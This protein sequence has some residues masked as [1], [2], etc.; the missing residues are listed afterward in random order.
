[1]VF[2]SKVHRRIPFFALALAFLVQCG[3]GGGGSGPAPP[4]GPD[5]PAPPAPPAS[6]T[7]FESGDY[8]IYLPPEI[9]TFRGVYWVLSGVD[10]REI[11]DANS[12]GRFFGLRDFQAFRGRVL[13][14]AQEHGLAVMGSRLPRTSQDVLSAMAELATTS[15]RPELATAPLLLT[16]FSEGGC[17]AYDFTRENPDRVIGFW[18]ERGGCHVE[19]DGLAAKEVPGLL[20][21][22]GADTEA[23][24]LNVTALFENNRP[25]GALWALAV[26]PGARHDSPLGSNM[27]FSWIDAVLESRLPATAA[28]GASVVLRP[29]SEASGW[30]GDRET[31]AVAPFNEYNKDVD[32]ASWLPSAQAAADWSS[33]VSPGRPI[34]CSTDAAD[35]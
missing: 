33:F 4:S 17:F 15:Q 28:P 13:A 24:C 9:S 2:D 20:V 3:G 34:A 1:M 10:T 16:G 30:L 22:G 19:G 31:A 18:T 29:M 26:E 12:Q 27:E 23:R 8:A 32:Q 6:Q 7:V 35:L 25:E 11:V 21:I 5:P 14:L